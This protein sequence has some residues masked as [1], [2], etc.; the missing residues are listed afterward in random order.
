MSCD[1]GNLPGVGQ[2]ALR[3]RRY[4][5]S[6]LAPVGNPERFT[7]RRTVICVTE[8]LDPVMPGKG[9]KPGPSRLSYG[10]A[11]AQHGGRS[12]GDG[13]GGQWTEVLQVLWTTEEE[14]HRSSHGCRTR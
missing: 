8:D 13:P 10:Q 12:T 9:A 14:L 2:Q 4:A 3:Y 11:G 7:S 5:G 1:E 6:D